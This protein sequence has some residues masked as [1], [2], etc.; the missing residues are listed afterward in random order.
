MYCEAPNGVGPRTTPAESEEFAAAYSQATI[1]RLGVFST[2]LSIHGERDPPLLDTSS[3]DGIES[4][5][6]APVFWGES[7]VP[8]EKLNARSV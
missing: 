6:Q 5:R 3:Q 4:E 8:R 2:S 1:R 7:T